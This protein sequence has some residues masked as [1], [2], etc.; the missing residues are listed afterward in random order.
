MRSP[1]VPVVL[2]V[3]SVDSTL[4]SCTGNAWRPTK[5]ENA[6][7]ASTESLFSARGV[8]LPLLTVVRPLSIR[9]IL[10]I[11][12]I[13]PGRYAGA[14]SCIAGKLSPPVGAFAFSIQTTMCHSRWRWLAGSCRVQELISVL[15]GSYYRSY[16]WVWGGAHQQRIKESSETAVALF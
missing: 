1:R 16:Q 9:A 10:S 2:A 14:A 7:L 4:H 8:L 5:L 6:Q 11:I 12:V 15:I 13:A 3:G